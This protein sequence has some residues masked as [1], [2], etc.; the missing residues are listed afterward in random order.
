[1]QKL[2]LFWTSLLRLIPLPEKNKNKKQKH[3]RTFCS[4]IRKQSPKKNPNPNRLQAYHYENV[5]PTPF[6]YNLSDCAIEQ[7]LCTFI[8]FISISVKLLNPQ[9]VYTKT[10]CLMLREQGEK[11]RPT[12]GLHSAALS[13]NSSPAP[14]DI[15][16]CAGVGDVL[17]VL[18]NGG[19]KRRHLYLCQWVVK[20]E[21]LQPSGGVAG[22]WV[23]QRL[24]SSTRPRR[25]FAQ[26]A[27]PTLTFSFPP[28]FFL[29]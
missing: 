26:A 8:W 15:S 19:R 20:A 1:M 25:G 22:V 7:Q 16:A 3:D 9:S 29:A 14:N 18:L 11:S 4:K 24:R 2:Q 28:R 21:G 27:E 6:S 10:H 13:R 12:A 23:N 17:A 5:A